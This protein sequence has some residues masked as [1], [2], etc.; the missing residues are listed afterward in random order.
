MDKKKTA[1]AAVAA[2]ISASGA[3]VEA[4][5]DNPADVLQNTNVEPKVQH[6]DTDAGGAA[7]GQAQDEEKGAKATSMKDRFREGILALPLGVRFLFVL[8]LWFIGS[9]V[10]AG[11]HLLFMALS[12]FA[13]LI[14]SFLLFVAVIGA[15]FTLTAKAMFPDLPLRKILCKRNIVGILIASGV[16]FAADMILGVTWPEYGQVKTL[17]VAGLILVCLG[18]LVLWFARRENARRKKEAA[19][20]DE[21]AAAEE[22]LTYTSLGQTFT[23]RPSKE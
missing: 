3:A 21:E 16:A 4:T 1:A 15:A 19:R 12:P 8:P 18:S 10:M 14:L 2:V 22:S 9:L 20:L 11:G 5:F 6:I 13:H 23:V 17:V 7:D